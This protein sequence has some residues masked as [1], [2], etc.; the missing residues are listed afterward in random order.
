MDSL[1]SMQ[2]SYLILLKAGGGKAESTVGM[3]VGAH[4]CCKCTVKVL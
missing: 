1:L 2:L 4:V 3:S